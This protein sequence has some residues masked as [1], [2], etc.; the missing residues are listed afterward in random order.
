M[1]RVVVPELLDSDTGTPEQV[2]GSLADLRMFNR[3]FGGVR[4]VREMLR[5]VAEERGLTKLLWL[6]VAGANGDVATFVAQSLERNG[7]E[8]HA[9][10]VDRAPSHM[11][12]SRPGVSGDA[13]AL[14]FADDS[15]D[16]VASSLFAHH[17]EPEEMKLFVREGLRVAR[18][19]FVVHD[20]IRHPLHLAMA[21][22]GAPIYRS[23]ITR[24][25]AP[26]SVRRAYTLEE[27]RLMMEEAGATRVEIESFFLFRMGAIAWKPIT[28]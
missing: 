19:A 9:V 12:G 26:A 13:L 1:K 18:H 15:F 2:Q 25:D 11:N 14:P 21:R 28:I 20:L 16:V 8:S 10:I 6:D 7:I 3:R 23:S 4:T 24:H 5:T 27:M 17:L 22:V